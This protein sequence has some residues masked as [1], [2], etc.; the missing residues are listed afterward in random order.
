MCT[1]HQ[2]HCTFPTQ[3]MYELVKIRIIT[4][5]SYLHRRAFQLNNTVFSVIH[6]VNFFVYCTCI[7]VFKGLM[8]ARLGEE[9]LTWDP[10]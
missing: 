1:G 4:A 8:A 6:E 3:F 5:L 10:Y 2:K 7:L 9:P